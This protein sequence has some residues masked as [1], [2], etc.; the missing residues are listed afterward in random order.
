MIQTPLDQSEPFREHLTTKQSA[1]ATVRIDNPDLC[2]DSRVL[3]NERSQTTGWITF[4]KQITANDEIESTY[5][6]FAHRVP[7][8][9]TPGGGWIP[10]TVSILQRL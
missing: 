8:K 5:D 4:I 6:G 1:V 9:N 2:T 3:I 7:F 10:M